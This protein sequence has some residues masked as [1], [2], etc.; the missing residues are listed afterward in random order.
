MPIPTKV[1]ERLGSSLKRFQPIL[2]SAKDRDVGEA[3][4]STIVKDI[5]SEMLGYDKYSEITAEFQIKSTYCDLALKID[6]KLVVLIEVK[7]IGTELKEMHTKQA[8]DYAANQ[9]VEWVFL[10][11]GIVW[12]VFRVIFAQPIQQE[13]VIEVSMTDL[14]A[15][16]EAH[17]DTLYML[18][19]EAHAKA[20]LDDYHTQRQAMSRFFLGAMLLS[21]PVID[22]VRRE[23]R[24]VSPGVRFESD[25]IREA[26]THEVLKREVLEGDKAA[27]ARRKIARAQAKAAAP[28]KPKMDKDGDT[29]NGG[30]PS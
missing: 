10:T 27:E 28:A 14:S 22:V 19:R 7:A 23:L 18:T 30:E 4:T 11:N 2:A 26:I 29:G 16:N 9:G 21:D 6:G 8:V 3:D 13:Q 24:K 25:E 20:A 12:K 17:L 15:R 1:A 5:L